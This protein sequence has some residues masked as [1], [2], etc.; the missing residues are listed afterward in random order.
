MVRIVSIYSFKKILLV[1]GTPVGS[2]YIDLLSLTETVDFLKKWHSTRPT[3][4]AEGWGGWYMQRLWGRKALG[5]CVCREEV[6]L[7]K[8][9]LEIDAGPCAVR[10]F[11]FIL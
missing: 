5:G 2:G 7:H 6:E 4:E 1:P 8:S 11:D 3:V 9:Q 10:I